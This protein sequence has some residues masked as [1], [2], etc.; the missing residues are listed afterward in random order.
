MNK[1]PKLTFRA[2]NFEENTNMMPMFIQ[3]EQNKKQKPN[4]NFFTIL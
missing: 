3:D 2:M 1:L 4:T